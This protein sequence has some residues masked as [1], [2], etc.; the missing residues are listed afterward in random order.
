[1]AAG[2]LIYQDWQQEY[3]GLLLGA[4]SGYELIS[5][6]EFLGYPNARTG[7][8]PRFAAHGAVAG[9]HTLPEKNFTVKWD[10]FAS[11]SA[12]FET[13]RRDV[14]RAFAVRTLPTD[15]IPLIY[16]IDGK[17]RMIDC[18]P[19]RLSLPLDLDTA[20]GY[21][22][23]AVHFEAADPF[24]V[25]YE[26]YSSNF[27]VGTTTSGLAFPL[28]FPLIF[29]AGT[30]NSASIENDGTAPATWRAE[31][32][33]STPNPKIIHLESGNFIELVGFTVAPGDV[34]EIDSKNKTILLNGT[35]SRRSFMTNASRWFDLQPGA[36][37][38][39]FSSGGVT[40]GSLTIYWRDTYWSA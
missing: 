17:K 16:Q 30:G 39:Q 24:A 18:R 15:I 23:W 20:L 10:I 7:T 40:T 37:T 32:T 28:V 14:E 4:D 34:L 21:T 5:A 9:K 22:E 6:S 33:G 29:G 35:A 12:D 36:N 13:K 38:I 27:T 31:I 8:L 11:S 26:E 2:D 3:N 19:L 25:S 1:M